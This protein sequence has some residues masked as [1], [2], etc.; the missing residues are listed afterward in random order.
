MLAD[1]FA[2]ARWRG[3]PRGIH[4]DHPPERGST[5]LLG[6]QG[7]TIVAD[8]EVVRLLVSIHAPAGGGATCRV[9][10]LP[11]L[12]LV[13]IHAPAGGATVQSIND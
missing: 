1:S 7:A 12:R 8:I 5:R 9:D 4:R 3:L 2:G 11:R 13:S 6:A 10:P